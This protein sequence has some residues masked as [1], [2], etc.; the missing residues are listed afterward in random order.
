[1]AVDAVYEL[2]SMSGSSCLNLL[3]FSAHFGCYWLD[4]NVYF[5][6]ILVLEKLYI[7]VLLFTYYN[8]TLKAVFGPGSM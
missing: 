7:A 2:V 6:V 5:S 1:M 4:F 8:E 3:A